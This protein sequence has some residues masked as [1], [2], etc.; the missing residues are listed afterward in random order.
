MLNEDLKKQLVE[1]LKAADPY[2]IILFGSHAYGVPDENSDVDLLVI[3]ED[4]FLPRNFTEK[5]EIYLRVAETITEIEKKVPI[6]LIVH[7]KAMNKK[8]IELGSMFARKIAAH[9]M[10]LYEKNY[11]GVAE[12]GKG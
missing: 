11:R 3:T 9:G 4:D 8:F 2:K 5:N 6:D 12:G 1:M 10:I 7:T